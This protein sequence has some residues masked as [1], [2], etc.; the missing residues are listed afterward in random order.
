MECVYA[1]IGVVA[2][3]KI[4]FRT[5]EAFGFWFTFSSESDREKSFNRSAD[6]HTNQFQTI[7]YIARL[8]FARAQLFA[9]YFFLMVAPKY[10]SIVEKCVCLA[11]SFDKLFYWRHTRQPSIK[12]DIVFIIRKIQTAKI[13]HGLQLRAND[14]WTIGFYK[15]ANDENEKQLKQRKAKVALICH[16]WLIIALWNGNASPNS[17]LQQKKEI[18]S[19]N[20]VESER[21]RFFM[22]KRWLGKYVSLN[23]IE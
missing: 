5:V 2:A 19:E 11:F 4:S 17:W 20:V 15:E 3:T 22:G 21:T 6:V 8:R 7:C 13:T 9:W 12:N 1:I 16:M 18:Q 23:F 10:R 14:S